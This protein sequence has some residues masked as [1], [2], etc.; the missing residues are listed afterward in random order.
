VKRY[1]LRAHNRISTIP[2][3]KRTKWKQTHNYIKTPK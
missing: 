3:H 2:K 1:F